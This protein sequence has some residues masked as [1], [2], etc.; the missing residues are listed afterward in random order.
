MAETNSL[1]TAQAAIDAEALRIVLF[2]LPLAGK[3]SLLGAL[4]ESGRTQEKMLEGALVDRSQGLDLLSRQ[5]YDGQLLERPEEVTPYPVTFQPFPAAEDNLTEPKISAVLFASDGAAATELLNRRVLQASS[6]NLTRALLEADALVLVVDS[7]GDGNNES[8]D[9]NFGTFLRFLRLLRRDRSRRAEVA[10]LPI[11]LVLSKCDLLAQPGDTLA[12]WNARMDD[13]KKR[14]ES[15]FTDFL[16]RDD[17]CGMRDE[18]NTPAVAPSSSSLISHSSSLSLPFGQVNLHVWATSVRMP[19]LADASEQPRSPYGVAEL[20]R[21]VFTRAREYRTRY[22]RASRNLHWTVAGSL[23]VLAIM[24]AL[25][26]GI[27]M[28]TRRE[29]PASRRLQTAIDAYRGREAATPSGRL[30]EPLQARISELTELQN[31]PAFASLPADAR[32]FAQDRLQELREYMKLKDQLN[33]IPRPETAH[34]DADLDQIENALQRLQVPGERQSE[35]SQTEVV[36]AREHRLEECKRLRVAITETAQW[37]EQMIERGWNLW[38]FSAHRQGEPPPWIDWQK[39]VTLL[40]N[41]VEAGPPSLEPPASKFENRRL[42]FDFLMRFDKTAAANTRWKL[43][44]SKLARLRGLCTAL[45]LDERDEGRGMRDEKHTQASSS[46]ASSLVPPSSAPLNVPPDFKMGQAMLRFEDLERD[47]PRFREDFTLS[48]VPEAAVAEIRSAA[49]AR[50]RNLL[51]AAQA[52]VLSRLKESGPTDEESLLRWRNLIPWLES[53]DEGRGM[54]DEN[55][56]SPTAS[57]PSSLNPRPSSLDCWRILATVLARLQDPDAADPV[58]ALVALLKRDQFELSV[59]TM[60]LSLPDSLNL[61]PEGKL[62]LHLIPRDEGRRMKDE[63]NTSTAPSFTSSLIRHSSSLTFQQVGEPKH[64][65]ATSEY[66]FRAAA[67]T[68]LVYRPG[69]TFWADIPVKRSDRP[70]WV[71]TWTRARSLLYQFECL[72][73]PPRLH[74][75]EQENTTGEVARDIRVQVFPETGVPALPVIMPEVPL[76]LDNR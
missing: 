30:R 66:T 69:D 33:A 20:F 22:R 28:N 64:E 52:L 61:R 43:V 75:K 7:V 68:S 34:N 40:L 32:T 3:S 29:D 1:S 24:I 58:N 55:H 67:A 54:K 18:K 41:Q 25:A 60:A 63:N 10:G 2:G 48:D 5:L 6:P 51:P 76:K 4:A 38:S 62:I 11:Y 35:W 37:Y 44:R 53:R 56:P 46:F 16:S 47:Y 74:R 27:L 13:C 45:G 65:S 36:L 15:Q 21:E 49:A 59:S 26:V 72:S 42:S 8:S 70:G 73:L 17:G 57:S 19:P 9:R 31:R 14:A 23:A 12:D 39:R 50:F 71:L